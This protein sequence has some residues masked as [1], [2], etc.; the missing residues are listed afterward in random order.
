MKILLPY[1]QHLIRSESFCWGFFLATLPVSTNCGLWKM[2][3]QIT[4]QDSNQLMPN[5]KP[6]LRRYCHHKEK[7]YHLC[8]E[9]PTSF[10]LPTEKKST[11]QWQPCW[12]SKW[13]LRNV[14]ECTWHTTC[15][16]LRTWKGHVAFKNDFPSKNVNS[17]NASQWHHQAN[18]A[19]PPRMANVKF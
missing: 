17:S 9:T 8:V 16:H 10:K 14:L 19:L 5:E 7:Y 4:W 3:S 2:A 1:H 13:Y 18:F 11:S 15:I 6:M 12:Y